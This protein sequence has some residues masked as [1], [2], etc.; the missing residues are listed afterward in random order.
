MKKSRAAAA[1]LSA[2]ALMWLI[3]FAALQIQQFGPIKGHVVPAT[4]GP[5]SLVRALRPNFP[6][7]VISG[8]AYSPGE[9]R[10]A[11]HNDAV[12][13]AHYANFDLGHAKMVRLVD[14][15]YQYASYRRGNQ[16]YWTKRKL[17][18][19]KGELLLT[20]GESY[21]R[22]R[23]GNRLSDK[24]HPDAVSR[25]EPD[26]A[27]LSLPPL[28]S[29]LL[30]K[31]ALATP[32][33]LGDIPIYGSHPLAVQTGAL[34]ELSLSSQP[35]TPTIEPLWGGQP[36]ASGGIS[37]V[38]PLVPI[39]GAPAGAGTLS[40]PLNTAG[41]GTNVTPLNQQPPPVITPVPEPSTIFMFLISL[42]VSVW[43]LLRISPR[44]EAE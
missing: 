11:D 36:I 18:I 29:D 38:S 40:S 15:R 8:G 26:T 30:A 39:G 43:A 41:S 32:P 13:R 10:F 22:A 3:Y 12:V 27:L 44:K 5:S 9:L 33:A 6:Y 17:R 37:Q 1:S 7:S 21:A 28:N 24:P 23:C 2:V 42:A 4:E 35:I 14:D 34:P 16:I 31:L 20:D 25:H 19:P